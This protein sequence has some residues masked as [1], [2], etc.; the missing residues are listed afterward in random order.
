MMSITISQVRLRTILNSGGTLAAEAEINLDGGGYGRASAPVAIVPGR[1]EQ[2]RTALAGLHE[3]DFILDIPITLSGQT[4]QDQKQFDDFLEQQIERYGADICLSLS[5]AFARAVAARQGDTLVRYICSLAET[6]PSMPAPLVAVFSG[7]IHAESGSLPFQQIML[8]VDA[9]EA[10]EAVQ[11]VLQ[12][13]GSVEAELIKTEAF[14]SYSASS[15][16]VT[17]KL[18]ADQMLDMLA[19]HIEQNGYAHI[20]RIAIDVA[21]EHLR[22]PNGLYRFGTSE[23]SSQELIR[24]YSDLCR[25]YPISYIEDPFDPTDVDAWK[26]LRTQ[27]N[28]DVL[29]VGDDLFATNSKYVDAELANAILLKMNQA[30]TLSATLRA[31]LK[32]RAEKMTLCVSHRSLETEDTFMCDLA[33]ALGAHLIKVGGPRRG[34]RIAKYNQLLRLAESVCEADFRQ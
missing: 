31:A 16:M 5:L 24:R 18:S 25:I 3:Q 34:D 2:A 27:L 21:A 33:V 17:R 14:H 29:V 11:A 19:K 13:Y 32:A 6:R 15:G 7:G 9:A 20:A 12:I 23:I 26:T 30:G 28:N 1:R 8:T 22:S 4:Y 10:R